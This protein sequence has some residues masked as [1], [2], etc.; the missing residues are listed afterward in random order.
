MGL[1]TTCEYIN[2]EDN[3]AHRIDACTFLHARCSQRKLKGVSHLGILQSATKFSTGTRA[4]HYPHGL[5]SQCGYGNPLRGFKPC[6][7]Q[8]RRGAPSSENEDMVEEPAAPVEVPVPPHVPARDPQPSQLVHT[9]TG[10]VSR[11][12]ARLDL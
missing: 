12:P 2:C 10:R 6:R 3:T 1:E 11:P 9:R 7:H 4:L 8:G 5:L